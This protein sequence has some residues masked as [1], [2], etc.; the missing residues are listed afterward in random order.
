MNIGPTH[1]Q[2]VVMAMMLFGILAAS[3]HAR[4]YHGIAMHGIP[5]YAAG[6]RHFD[7]VRPDAPKDGSLRLAAT[8]SFDSLNPYIITGVPAR[9]LELVF[10]SLLARSLDEPFSL[11]SN[12]ARTVEMPTDRSWIIF[13]LD[14]RAR[15]HDGSAVTADDVL[16]SWRVLKE[17]GRP[18][19]RIYYARVKRAEKLG[20]RRIKFTFGTSGNW[21]M[22]LIMG[23][24]PVLSRAYYAR[25]PFDK[26]SL[27]PPLGTGPYRVI[28]VQPGR[29]ITYR[30]DPNYWG[31][32]LPV[33][34]GRYNFDTVRYD[35][36]RDGHIA[37]EAFKAGE[38]DF[39][40]EPD[41][42]RWATGYDHPAVSDG[43][44]VRE[45]IPHSRPVGMHALVLNARRSPFRDVRVR[46]ALAYA[47]DFEWLNRTLYHGAY[48]R[49]ASYFENSEFAA[50][51]NIGPRELALLEPYGE[52]LPEEVFTGLYQPPTTSGD[53]FARSN[54]QMAFALLKQAG[55]Q[56]RDL[57][58]VE[59]ATGRP[60]EFE[61][62]LVKPWL[63]RVM[64]PYAR[65]LA[66]LGIDAR[67]RTV[68]TAQYQYRL[69]EYDY[70]AIVYQWGQSLSPGNEQAFYWGSRAADTPGSRNYAGIKQPVVDALIEQ[71]A[72]ARDR[73]SLVAATRAL[74]RVL[75]WGHYVVPLFHMTVDRVAYWSHIARPTVTPLY[76]TQI[77]TWWFD[78]AKNR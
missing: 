41:P 46:R 35:Y 5:R 44:I 60:F 9:G 15:F 16:F 78:S 75:L 67:I 24:M 72:G 42:G 14:P 73:G 55:W 57:R 1:L 61:I 68:D 12:I 33:N 19:T 62:L 6:F 26:T 11:Y 71:I 31:A 43:R 48:T 64:L 3:A 50:R 23:L 69:T 56:V 34:A 66:K 47:F 39:H 10:Q 13:N 36:Y 54:L 22:P 65:Q 63:E 37:F 52:T 49:T 25:V 38:Y 74:D 2:S 7:Y 45:A 20:E 29:S 21:E 30:R 28:T 58:L 53:G 59:V 70:D 76:G 77:D 8:G 17:K 40:F 4:T 27:E 51:G 32:H 18:N